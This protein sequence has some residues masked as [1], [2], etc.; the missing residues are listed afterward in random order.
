MPVD[1]R[2]ATW[3]E[4]IIADFR[5]HS[6]QVTIPPFVGANLLLLTTTGAKSQVP[7]TSPIGYT[8]DGRRYVIVGSNSGGPANSAW[9]Y[10]IRADPLVTV[11]V[12]TETFRA[13]ATE[14]V[15]AERR[16]LFDAHAEAIPQ[17]RKYEAMTERRLPVI[18]LERTDKASS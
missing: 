16:R 6:G 18:V 2:E 1:S 10:N 17:F 4:G 15:G 12:G 13:R 3:N 7:R 9:L 8:R 11:E 5:A 14:S